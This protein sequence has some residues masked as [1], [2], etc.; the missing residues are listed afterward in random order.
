MIECVVDGGALLGECPVWSDREQVLYWVDIDGR[1]VHR[2]DPSNGEDHARSTPGRPG[3]FAL[4]RT[5]GRLLL[6]MEHRL[7][8]FDWPSGE[9]THWL[10]LEPA[11]TGNRLNDGRCDP[12]GRFW[13]G[14]MH[15]D[16]RAGRSTGLLHRVDPDGTAA[17]VRG[18]IGV[19][20]GLAFDDHRM[21]F[22][23]SPRRTVW[24]FDFDV[25]TGE[26]TGERVFFEFDGLPGK[27]D[28]ACLDADGCYWIACV[29]GWAVARVT[30]AGTVDLLIELPVEKP[31]MPAFGGPAR[32]VLFVT[33][34]G[35][36][37]SMGSAPD[38]PLAGGLFAIDA[39][40][41]GVP[42]PEYAGDPP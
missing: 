27:P 17:V 10:D 33:S 16:T 35:S 30:P 5:E 26:A 15:E 19:S 41:T 11:G 12:A 29:Y 25:A 6:A 32:N 42:E 1:A 39:G 13:V 37:G 8:W 23:D 38:Q 40:V 9:F 14:S 22:A 4:T 20:N 28:G 2:Y 31:T 34:I 7:G 36:G 18:A 24:T 21:F 3:S